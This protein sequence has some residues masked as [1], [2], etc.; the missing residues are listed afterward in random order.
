MCALIAELKST[1]LAS[2]GC[3]AATDCINIGVDTCFKGC[4]LVVDIHEDV[5][6]GD[7]LL[8][9]LLALSLDFIIRFADNKLAVFVRA[10]LHLLW[11]FAL[12]QGLGRR[13]VSEGAFGE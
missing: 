8:L 5:V 12:A 13:D 3:V 1:F 9:G 4:V 10:C 7:V 6:F 2:L 11:L